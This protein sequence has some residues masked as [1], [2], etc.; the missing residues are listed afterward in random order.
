MLIPAEG[1]PSPDQYDPRGGAEFVRRRLDRGTRLQ[2]RPF[3][4]PRPGEA[5]PDAGRLTGL[6]RDV[7]CMELSV[8]L[9]SSPRKGAESIVRAHPRG[10]GGEASLTFQSP[11]PTAAGLCAPSGQRAIAV[12]QV[13]AVGPA[14]RRG[15]RWRER[16][17]GYAALHCP[18]P[19]PL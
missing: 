16:D 15:A 11:L 7:A 13:A 2:H 1:A 4:K 6:Q 9:F 5:V 18:G 19:S 8:P 17:T 10:G 3:A 12:Q 14:S